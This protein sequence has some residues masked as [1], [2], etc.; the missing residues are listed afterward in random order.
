MLYEKPTTTSWLVEMGPKIYFVS[1][2]KVVGIWLQEDLIWDSQIDHLCKNDTTQLFMLR[3]LK[4]FGFNTWELITVCRRYILR[5][6]NWVCR[7]HLALLFLLQ[8]QTLEI[9]QRRA[10]NLVLLTARREIHCLNFARS[11]LK[12]KRTKMLPSS[13]KKKKK[14]KNPDIRF[15]TNSCEIAP[16]SLKGGYTHSNMHIF[17]F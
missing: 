8:F 6:Y 2:T 11:L 13:K 10:C 16:T 12:F 14:K 9:I 3:A 7:C 5:L 1:S 17:H 4:R 15:M